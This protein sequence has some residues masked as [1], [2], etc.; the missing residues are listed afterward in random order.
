MSKILDD[1]VILD[2][3]Q[4]FKKRLIYTNPDE[5][6]IFMISGDDIIFVSDYITCKY[7]QF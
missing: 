4:D 2:I 7:F 5:G 6:A 1:Q 3:H